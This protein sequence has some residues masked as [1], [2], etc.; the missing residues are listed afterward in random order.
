MKTIKVGNKTIGEGSPC[1]ISFEPSATYANLKSAKLMIK[2]TASSGADAI[3]F[4]TF[5]PGDAE[6]LM[7]KKDIMIDFSTT[8]GK[9]KESVYEALKRRELSEDNWKELINYAKELNVLFISTPV[10][11]ETI[12]FLVNANV[13]MLKVSKGDV[14][15]VL[16]IEHIAKTH[17]PVI[18]DGREK[19]EN[20]DKAIK[21]CEKNHNDKIMVLH[22]PSGYPVEN[23]GVHLNTLS[24]IQHKYDYPIGFA[25]HSKGG[26]MNY[27]AVALGAKM[28]EKTIT[29]DKTTE[30]VE[31]LMS[32]ELDE[33]KNFVQNVRAIED[34]MGDPNIFLTSRVEANARRALV[35]KQD[36]KKGEK[37]TLA[38]LDF[39]RP[40]DAGISCSEGFRVIEKRA[41]VDIAKDTFLKWSM[42]E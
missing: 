33:L 5:I 34:A 25:D 27:A 14:D 12:D 41:S 2:E 29:T 40:A 23:A 7:S 38:S 13:D 17:L 24:V 36:I 20:V 16:M 32:L 4:Q 26:N 28:L 10:F 15:N 3:K 11:I 37:I 6:R 30:H 8:T 19:F 9:K 1:L 22:C 39:Q 31:H 18:L 35:A 42:L 21:I